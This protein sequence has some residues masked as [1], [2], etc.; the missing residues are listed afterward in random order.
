MYEIVVGLAVPVLVAG[1]AFFVAIEFALVS[2]RWTRVEQLLEERHPGGKVVHHLVENLSDSLA[3][4]QLGITLSSL[5]LGWVGE[6]SIA[7][8]IAPWFE[9]LPI[10]WSDAV[11]HGFAIAIAFLVITYLHMVLGELVPR[12]VGIQ[13]AERV[14]IWLGPLLVAFRTVTRPLVVFMR[15]SGDLAVRL[16]RVPEPPAASQVHSPDEIDMLIE[17]GQ[18]AGVIQPDEAKYARAVF[19]LSDKKVR[20]VMVPRERVVTLARSA[21]PDDVLE[22]ARMSAHTRM[23]VWDGEP[24]NIV[25][26][27]NT[28]DLFHIFSLMNLVILEDAMYPALYVDPDQSLARALNLFR[29]ERR[30]M[31]VVRGP[32]GRFLGIVT[33]EDIVEE[34]VGEIEDEH[35]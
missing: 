6:P 17:E 2:V 8:S 32:E 9:K 30:Q 1:N 24:D 14:A 5:A 23:P 4:T 19:E 7:H 31:A 12:A 22:T 11:A 15:S 18:E 34:I 10:P 13:H 33:L 16:L 29:R 28:K 3:A 20:D 21:K 35:D 27:V 25:G 26:I